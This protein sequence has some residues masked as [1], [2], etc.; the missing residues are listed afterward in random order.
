MRDCLVPYCRLSRIEKCELPIARWSLYKLI[1]LLSQSRVCDVGRS[2]QPS[3]Y[4]LP[5]A[6]SWQRLS[7]LI[8][9]IEE[10]RKRECRD[11][12]QSCE[13]SSEQAGTRTSF[14]GIS[15]MEGKAVRVAARM[16]PRGR[17]RHRW[18]NREVEWAG[19]HESK[20][21][22]RRSFNSLRADDRVSAYERYCSTGNGANGMSDIEGKM[23][24]V[25]ASERG[26]RTSF[27]PLEIGQ[28][29]DAEGSRPE[30]GGE[31]N[32]IPF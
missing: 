31:L 9:S 7:Q 27:K 18:A 4:W 11:R 2:T 8:A 14:K 1:T 22:Q 12:R 5:R 13:G 29:V 28:S 10:S 24:R 15:E 16:E 6:S 30:G 25:G 19:A 21:G 20:R 23:T 3:C 26:Q 32:E 17:E